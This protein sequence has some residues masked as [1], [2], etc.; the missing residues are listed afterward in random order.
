MADFKH[1]SDDAKKKAQDMISRSH[2]FKKP[3]L[4]IAGVV[5]AVMLGYTQFKTYMI[6]HYKPATPPRPVSMAP[7]VQKDVPVFIEAFGNMNTLNNTD[8]KSQV[9][10][11]IKEVRFKDGDMV[12]AGDILF[13]IDPSLYQADYDKS[14]AA[15]KQDQIDLKMKKDTLARNEQ[16]VG[17]NLI[18]QQ[19]FE[20][21]QTDVDS[22]EARLLLDRASADYAKIN[23]DYCSVRAPISGLAGKRQVDP[24]NI[25]PANTGPTLVNIKTID[26]LY[27]DFTITERDFQSVRDAT[28]N[29]KLKVFVSPD[30]PGAAEKQGELVFL[31]NAVDN[32]TGTVLL[33]AKLNNSDLVFWPGQFVRVRLILSTLSGAVLVPSDAVQMGQN[34]PY[35]FTVKEGSTAD[36]H[37]IML[38][39]KDGD[40]VVIKNGLKPGDIVVTKGQLMLRPG[41]KLIDASKI[42]A[43]LSGKN[44]GAEKAGAKK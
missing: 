23:L 14:M 44:S 34:G 25:V 4:I 2:S 38:G 29:A 26:E 16:L 36:L 42:P 30:E 1:L 43:Q 24:G 40:L 15:I 6:R 27:V 28:A 21:Y 20:K 12:K 8:V 11:E 5:I 3:L 22:A 17:K 13:M 9:T 18:S 35:I 33:R 7:A 41:T 10:G 39:P 19:D 32:T 37:F 31:D